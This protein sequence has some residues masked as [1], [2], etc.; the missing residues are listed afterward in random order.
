MFTTQLSRLTSLML[1]VS[2]VY[3][4]FSFNQWQTFWKSLADDSKSLRDLFS[5]QNGATSI[6]VTGYQCCWFRRRKP[7]LCLFCDDIC[8]CVFIGARRAADKCELFLCPAWTACL[9][10][11]GEKLA[12]R[13]VGTRTHDISEERICNERWQRAAVLM[14]RQGL[15]CT[16][17]HEHES[18]QQLPDLSQRWQQPQW[19]SWLYVLQKMDFWIRVVLKL[20]AIVA[21]DVQK[22]SCQHVKTQ[23]SGFGPPGG[24]VRPRGWISIIY[25]K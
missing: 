22:R 12:N 24:S 19:G 23:Q 11:M 10:N 8:E 16:M 1:F 7:D 6:H 2:V 5:N 4:S 15:H 20:G 14:S 21:S 18:C 3:A 17:R 13:L 9:H 25:K